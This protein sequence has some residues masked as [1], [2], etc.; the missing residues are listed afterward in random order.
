MNHLFVELNYRPLTFILS[1]TVDNSPLISRV[2]GLQLPPPDK[3]KIYRKSKI[4]YNGE[5]LIVRS[6]F[7]TT[8]N[9]GMVVSKDLKSAEI[10]II[11]TDTY[12]IIVEETNYI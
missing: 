8:D 1:A 5:I 4:K 2:H 10:E 11:L 3:R 12:E 7:E 9:V 6:F